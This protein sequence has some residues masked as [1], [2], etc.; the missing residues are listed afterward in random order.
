MMN[1][2]T[3][4]ENL[5]RVLVADDS[6]VVREV[7]KEM[8]ES[9]PQIRVVGMASNGEEAVA[10]TARLKPD[11]ITMD[12][13]MPGMDGME[14]TRRIMAYNPTPV[15]IF[16]SYIDHEGTYSS[17]DALS[18]GALDVVEKPTINPSEEWDNLSNALLEKVKALAR[19]RVVTHV[20]GKIQGHF[21]RPRSGA[22]SRPSL[23]VIGI[24]VSTGGPKV[25]QALLS[26]L[27]TNFSLAVLVVQHITEGFMAGLVA[28]LQKPC[29]IPLKIAEEGDEVR[30][31]RILF[32]SESHHLVVL[33]EGTVHLSRAEPLNSHRPAVDVTFRSLAAVYGRRA[34]G[35][36][37]T[38]MGSDGADGLRAIHDVGGLT[39]VQNEE[40]CTIFGM[41]RAA[42]ELGAAQ[43]VL[44]VQELSETL[45]TLHQLHSSSITR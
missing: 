43:H 41:P 8:L 19:V 13:K 28:W 35:V 27:P 7:L 20:Q 34:V 23:E 17:L 16:S 44:S 3:R 2:S 5:V 10:M 15:L 22:M 9:D 26:S 14:A 6:G 45:I 40:S 18:A 33:P 4:T 42:I 36:L 30:P 38:G 31:G 21:R 12:I 39:L 25:L 32:A 24:G 11:L 29:K 37:L 1:D